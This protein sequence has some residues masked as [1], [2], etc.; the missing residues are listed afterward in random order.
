MHSLQWLATL[1]KKSLSYFCNIFLD[2]EFW[3]A[4]FYVKKFK[5]PLETKLTEPIKSNNLAFSKAIEVEKPR[6]PKQV[7]TQDFLEVSINQKGYQLPPLSLLS[8][9]KS[10]ELSNFTSLKKYF[11]PE[12]ILKTNSNWL[13]LVIKAVVDLTFT[14][15]NPRFL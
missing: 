6:R 12:L 4:L 14:L 2:K 10:L 3:K 9:K 8:N 7:K 11:L 1:L 5:D 13:S 15:K